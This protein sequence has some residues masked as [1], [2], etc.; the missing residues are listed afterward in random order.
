MP[1]VAQKAPY[2]LFVMDDNEPM[3]PREDRDNFGKM[4]CWHRRYSLGDEHDYKDSQHFLQ[5]LLFDKLAYCP[6][7][8]HGKPVYDY[9]K[10]GKA[11]Y[12]RLEHN[13]TT[14]E[15]ELYE[16]NHVHGGKDWFRL[17]SCPADLERKDVPGW[18]LDECIGLLQTNELLE[19][20]EQIQG[21]VI[22]PLYLYDHGGITIS[23][24]PFSC[25][26]DSG[27]VGWIYADYDMI[28]NTA[29]SRPKP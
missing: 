8:S 20:T 3:N 14:Q 12:A 25:P 17:S 1:M 16:S 22:L 24:S 11:Q 29:Q 18:F 23:C 9:I 10:Q 6:E 27:Q 2:T 4:L 13:R 21:L 19:L 7:H 28:K 26:W 5:N 15:W